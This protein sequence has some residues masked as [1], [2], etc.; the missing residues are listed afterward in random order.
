MYIGKA[1]NL[2]KRVQQYFTPGSVRKQEMLVKAHT[3]ESMSVANE[4]E[5]LYLESNLIKKY[6]PPYNSLLKGDN[7]YCFIKI[8]KEDFPQILVTRQRKDDGAIYIGPKHQ[9]HIV[10]EFLHYLRQILQFRIS[11]PSEFNKG[12]LGSDFY[13][14][15]DR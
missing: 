14:G 15:L 10:K 2:H 13:F 7:N 6:Q 1:K 4:S 3:V 12:K 9:R 11:K 5:A 8:T